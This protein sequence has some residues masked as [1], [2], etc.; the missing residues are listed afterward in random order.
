MD[1]PKEGGYSFDEHGDLIIELKEN[2]KIIEKE[3]WEKQIPTDKQ[4]L[5]LRVTRGKNKNKVDIINPFIEVDFENPENT[6]FPSYMGEVA[7]RIFI[8]VLNNYKEEHVLNEL[9]VSVLMMFA[10]AVEKYHDFEYKF[11]NEIYQYTY[12][13][14]SGIWRETPESKIHLSNTNQIKNLSSLLLINPS[15]RKSKVVQPMS[16]KVS[17][18]I[19]LSPLE[20]FLATRNA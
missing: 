7:Q 17:E 16:D 14:E 3:F 12:A 4:L 18:E 6:V 1:K 10:R 15:A 5:A 9:D 20:R 8:E 13:T 11:A 19:E 2:K